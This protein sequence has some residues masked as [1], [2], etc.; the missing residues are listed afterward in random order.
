MTFDLVKARA[1]ADAYLS[2]TREEKADVFLS[3]DDAARFV[4]S[5]T[6]AAFRMWAK[7][8]GL[9][10]AH[11]GRRLVFSRRDLKAELRRRQLVGER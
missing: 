2:E 11:R 10:P 7:R 3:T 1:E 9:V 4:G 5:P 8:A 6:R